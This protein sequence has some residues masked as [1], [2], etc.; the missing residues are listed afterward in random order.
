MSNLLQILTNEHKRLSLIKEPQGNLLFVF[1]D[2]LFYEKVILKFISDIQRIQDLPFS[3][4]G[5][6]L[7]EKAGSPSLFELPQ[8]KSFLIILPSKILSADIKIFEN[9]LSKISDSDSFFIFLG[10]KSQ[11]N[12]FSFLKRPP[13]IGYGGN[14]EISFLCQ[15]FIQDFNQKSSLEQSNF[16]QKLKDCY[17]ESLDEIYNHLE[18]MEY[19]P[20]D[21][22][23]QNLKTSPYEILESISLNK[24]STFIN[25]WKDYLYAKGD[26]DYLMNILIIYFRS[27]MECFETKVSPQKIGLQNKISAK[28]L[29]YG[30]KNISVRT[31]QN[32]LGS[33]PLILLILRKN[34]IQEIFLTTYICSV[35]FNSSKK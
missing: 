24:K 3:K 1:T 20:M 12:L 25:R 9:Y 4:L 5:S 21:A 18:R 2:F 28:Y 27:L 31:A 33:A 35:L 22:F 23:R 13:F 15:V 10:N 30:L 7:M 32:F 34:K 26:L 14:T 11:K 6:Y 8:K 17:G 29:E 16:I 19:F